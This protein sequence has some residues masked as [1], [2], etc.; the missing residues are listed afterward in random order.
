MPPTSRPGVRRLLERQQG[1]VSRAQLADR[2][3]R[4]PVIDGWVRAGHL[5][6]LH[7]GVY[8]IAGSPWSHAQVALAACL[9]AGSGARVT[10]GFV[11]RE[12]GLRGVAAS[13]P[14]VLLRPGRRVRSAPFPVR[15]DLAVQLHGDR[16]AGCP[17][18]TVARALVEHATDEPDADRLLPLIDRARWAN[19]VTTE[20]VV[21]AAAALGP[22]HRGGVRVL[23][24]QRAG[25]LLLESPG[26]RSLDDALRGLEPPLEW[27][28]WVSPTR[29]VDALWRDAAVVVEYDGRASHGDPRDRA[30]D[31]VRDEE[32]AE[33]GYLVVRVTAADLQDPAALRKRL[34][35]IRRQRLA[36]A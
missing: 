35:R 16:V 7:R 10:A 31:A 28:V 20:Q 34:H 30:A 12:A 29:R 3:V 36:E 8:R 13:P 21:A 25:A 2:G 19:L 26:E 14:V 23:R 18:T 6:R 32:L 9:R 27:Q 1:V 5:E 4:A 24:L 33:L 22:R 11:L 17:A 15:A